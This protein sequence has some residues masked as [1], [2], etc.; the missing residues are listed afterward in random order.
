MEIINVAK[1]TSDKSTNYN[2]KFFK[3][4]YLKLNNST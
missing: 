3:N 1:E 2:E 4:K